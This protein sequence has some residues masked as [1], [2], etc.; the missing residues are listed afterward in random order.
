MS[1]S[2]LVLLGMFSHP[3][4]VSNA[5][6]S[7]AYWINYGSFLHF[8][9]NSPWQW[10]TAMVL[11]AIHAIVLF[12]GLPFF[13]ES[14]RFLALRGKEAKSRQ[15]LL[16]LRNIPEN[17]HLLVGQLLVSVSLDC[18]RRSG[19]CSSTMSIG[20]MVAASTGQAGPFITLSALS[21]L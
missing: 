7:S 15:V 19:T 12:V 3:R 11:Q 14:R 6:E 13:P 1:T 17:R 21:R 20:W 16:A 5:N 2:W 9:S 4:R 8:P 18:S 10:Q